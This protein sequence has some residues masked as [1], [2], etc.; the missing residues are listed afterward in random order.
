[1]YLRSLDSVFR[2]NPDLIRVAEIE[3]Q[4]LW[5]KGTAAESLPRGSPAELR[6]VAELPQHLLTHG[7]GCPIGGLLCDERQAPEFRLWNEGLKVPWTSEHLSI[8][9]VQGAHG[10]KPC[11]FLMPPLQ[12]VAQVRLAAANIRRRAASLGLPFAFETGVNYF[13]PRDC[14]MPDGEFFACVAEESDSGILLDL[15]NL[16]ANEKN[17]RATLQDVLAGIPLDR[18]WEVHLSGLEFAHG[19]W[20]DAHAGEIDP[21]LIAFAEEAIPRL[22]NLGAIIFEVAPDHLPSFGT[23]RFL[24][25]MEK[26][27]RL[28]EK[29]RTKLPLREPVRPSFAEIP[30]PTPEAWE[31]FI[32]ARMLHKDDSPLSSAEEV[33]VRSSD[34]TSFELYVYLAATFR[35]GAIAELFEHTTRLL[36]LGMG[37]GSLRGLMNRYVSATP[38][39]AFPTDEVLSFQR[40]LQANPVHVPGLEDLLKFESALVEASV[41]GG[42]ILVELSKDMD[43]MLADLA[44]GRLPGPSSDR[45]GTVLEICVDP[46]PS[47]RMLS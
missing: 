44:I 10:P 34:E 37:E 6:H 32:G 29:K 43:A 45:L 25:E 20:L 19:Y 36:L 40:Y 31:R 17:G 15:T 39:M 33:P 14:E 28:W 46:E 8:F 23:R 47:V 18:V 35:T 24:K 12:T 27:H 9:H 30:S 5:T 22:P 3:P 7:V 16:W 1:M 21:E 42:S 2:S 11:G 41:N 26:L 38:P 13:A 4:T